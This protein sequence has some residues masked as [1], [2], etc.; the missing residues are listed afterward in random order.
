MVP[1][2]KTTKLVSQ[3]DHTVVANAGAGA[4]AAA[5][6]IV[7]SVWTLDNACLFVLC[8]FVISVVMSVMCSGYFTVT[9][10]ENNTSLSCLLQEA[11]QI[12][13]ITLMSKTRNHNNLHS[14]KKT[15]SWLHQA[16]LKGQ[17]ILFNDL[18]K[19]LLMW[20]RSRF[21]AATT[22]NYHHMFRTATITQLHEAHEGSY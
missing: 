11:D 3:T 4:G 16:E 20:M 13:W 2:S 8:V 18:K 15:H 5:S 10:R 6:H 14:C 21:V 7:L 17:V 22:G 12:T 9:Q 1:G 19:Q